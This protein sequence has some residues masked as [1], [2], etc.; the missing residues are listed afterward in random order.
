MIILYYV[1]LR[2]VWVRRANSPASNHLQPLFSMGGQDCFPAFRTI[3]D[4]RAQWAGRHLR[5]DGS[6]AR[7]LLPNRNG[8]TVW[9]LK[10]IRKHRAAG[11]KSVTIHLE[12]R[13]PE[14]KYLTRPEPDGTILPPEQRSRR[15]KSNHRKNLQFAAGLRKILPHVHIIHALYEN[16][17]AI[18]DSLAWECLFSEPE[19][20]PVGWDADYLT[21]DWKTQK[22]LDPPSQ[23]EITRKAIQL[24]GGLSCSARLGKTDQSPGKSILSPVVKPR[25]FKCK[26]LKADRQRMV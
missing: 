10:F 11:A 2:R 20:L 8:A 19:S 1:T 9:T 21:N 23:D 5:L 7:N 3:G 15:N 25:H 6:W 4:T 13:R 22:T 14:W 12:S 26:Q 16:D 18:A 17:D 24:F